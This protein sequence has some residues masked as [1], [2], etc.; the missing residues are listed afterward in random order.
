MVKRLRR[1]NIRENTDIV[2]NFWELHPSEDVCE[3]S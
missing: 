1:K 3:K 2:A